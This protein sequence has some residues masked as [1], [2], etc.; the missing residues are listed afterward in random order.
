[1]RI[2]IVGAGGRGTAYADYMLQNP[3]SGRVVGVAEP[4]DFYRNRL[5]TNHGLPAKDACRDW[6]EIAARPK[7][8][9]AVLICTQDTMHEEPAAAFA[10]LGYHIL[11]EKPMA[12]SAEGCRRIVEAVQTAGVLFA[13]CH[14]MRYT[15]YTRVLKELLAQGVVGDIVNVQHYEPVGFWH[16]AHSFVRGGWRNE[17]ESSFMLLAKSCHDIDW[18]RHIIGRPCRRVSSFGSLVHFR[19][20][21]R[22][23]G[24]ADRCLD[25]A[26]ESACPYS[27]KRIYGRRLAAGQTDWPLDVVAP[28]ATADTLRAALAEGPSGRCVY[29]CDN[30]VVD[31]QVVNLEYAGGITASFTMCAFNPAMG[32]LT[33]IGGTRG[34]IDGD[35]SS[36]RIHDFMTEQWRT[37]DTAASDAGIAGGHGGGDSGLMAAF[38]AAVAAGDPSSIL[39]GPTETLETHLTTFAAETS[40]RLGKVVTV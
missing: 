5:A 26:V 36:L 9:D 1:M 34:Y 23:R 21:H 38:L 14:V 35:G 30:D 10:A 3:G 16:Q 29:A 8:A 24:A 12:P 25:C 15:R 37:V 33:R 17:A 4:R 31:N 39:S 32:R 6:R 22:P 19:P 13:V 20:E 7:F 2:L 40:R 28:E 11:L 27:A 18:L